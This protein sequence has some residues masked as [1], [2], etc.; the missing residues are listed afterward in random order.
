MERSGSAGVYWEGA[1][2]SSSAT[3]VEIEILS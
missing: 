1:A 3:V 2:T